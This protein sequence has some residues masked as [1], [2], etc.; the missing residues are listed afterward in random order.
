M[1]KGNRMCQWIFGFSSE[2]TGTKSE[3][4]NDRLETKAINSQKKV[5]KIITEK[6]VQ[7]TKDQIISKG[8]S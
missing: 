5:F 3:K 1:G 2:V 6:K 8:Q 7:G 4:D